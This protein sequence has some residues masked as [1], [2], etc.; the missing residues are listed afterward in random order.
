MIVSERV[1]ASNTERKYSSCTSGI[2]AELYFQPALIPAH[3]SLDRGFTQQSLE[4]PLLQRE[5]VR[6]DSDTV[7][8]ICAAS[9]RLSQVLATT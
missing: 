2:V 1:T 6:E 5:R 4:S 8:V 9:D 7:N 3:L